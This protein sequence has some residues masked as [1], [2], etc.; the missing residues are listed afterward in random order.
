MS[1]GEHMTDMKHQIL[2]LKELQRVEFEMLCHIKSHCE[3]NG[4]RF[5]LSN[6]TLLGAIKYKGFIPWDDDIDIFIP[7]EDY[8]KLIKQYQDTK[9]YKLFSPERVNDYNF[10]F[11]KLCAMET[12]R[13]EKN[14]NNG[15][16]LGVDIDIFPLDNWGK[17]AKR[18]V[19][20]QMALMLM[21]Q[22][23]KSI[24]ITSRTPLRTITK[25]IGAAICKIIG[26]R[27]FINRLLKNSIKQHGKTAYSGCVIWPV[28]GEH[29][30]IPSEVF[31]ETVEVEFEGENF[32][33]PIG[34][35]TYLHSLY[36]EYKNDPPIDKQKTHHRFV[37]Y[38]I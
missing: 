25:K 26:A 31:S 16:D 5:F 18:Q 32:P 10:P 27:Y 33:A 12:R 6:G 2:E 19:K 28:Y 29:E 14:N 37:A 9:K 3:D 4:Y 13:I 1:R 21:L 24:K 20:K 38:R 36:G 30:V 11:A 34:Y 15:V 17:K 23:A 22:L 7:R 35:D 8:D